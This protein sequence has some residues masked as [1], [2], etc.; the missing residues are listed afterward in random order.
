MDS[1]SQ[2]INVT[3]FGEQYSIRGDVDSGTTRRVAE[4]VNSKINELSGKSASQNKLKIA[5]LSALNIAGEL[6][7][8]RTQLEECRKQVDSL[9][10]KTTQLS[11][12]ID[13]VL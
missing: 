9:Q 1:S 13:S 11:H 8:S 5:I 6:F 2:G 4:Y 12:R 7:E 10:K 3:I